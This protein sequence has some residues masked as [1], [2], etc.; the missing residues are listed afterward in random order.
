MQENQDPLVMAELLQCSTEDPVDVLCRRCA[1]RGQPTHACTVGMLA[2]DGR[3]WS[4]ATTARHREFGRRTTT[5]AQMYRGK[6]VATLL[7]PVCRTNCG[8]YSPRGLGRRVHQGQSPLL[9]PDAMSVN[10]V[11][12][13]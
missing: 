3:R 2:Y 11:P 1:E 4:L 12:R 7:C 10:H 6:E 5:P 13:R 9:V 8:S